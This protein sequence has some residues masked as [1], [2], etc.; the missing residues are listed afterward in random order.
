MRDNTDA[1]LA[2]VARG[3]QVFPLHSPQGDACDCNKRDCASPAKHPRTMHGLLDATDNA[4]TISRWWTTWPHANV[5]VAT[6]QAS[7]IVVIDVDPIHGGDEQI[8]ALVAEHGTLPYGPAVKTGSGG[9]HYWFKHPGT[10]V[11]SRN[12]QIAPGVDVKGD[13]GYVVAPPSVHATGVSYEWYADLEDA[14]LPA[15]PDWLYER[16]IARQE[17]GETGAA[18]LP[19]NIAEG[20]RNSTLTSWAGV[21]RARGASQGEMFAFLLELNAQRCNPPLDRSEVAQIAASIARKEPTQAIPMLTQSAPAKT[22]RSSCAVPRTLTLREIQSKVYDP[23]KWA[24]PGLMPVGLTLLAGRSKMGKSWMMM[25]IA[26]AIAEGGLAF[27]STPVED[28]DV[29]YLAYEDYEARWQGRGK[30]LL[31]EVQLWPDRLH[32]A[33]T[34]CWPQRDDGGLEAIDA[35]LGQHPRARLVVMDTL[36]RFRGADATEGDKNA[37]AADYK[38]SGDLQELALKHEVAFAAVHHFR[39]SLSEVDWVDQ[40]SGTN[41]IGAA[42]DVIWGFVRERGD[43]KA[44]ILKTTGRDVMEEELAL[45]WDTTKYGWYVSGTAEELRGTQE[46]QEFSEAVWELG[47]GEPVHY[48][49]IAEVIG[50]KQNT[51]YQMGR[52]LT[53]RGDVIAVGGGFYKVVSTPVNAVKMAEN[54]Y[55][56]PLTGGVST[57][58]NEDGGADTVLTGVDMPLTGGVSKASAPKTLDFDSVDSKPSFRVVGGTKAPDEP[59]PTCGEV[60]WVPRA[61]GGWVCGTCKPWQTEVSR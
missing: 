56:N 43:N 35:W 29:L 34:G 27:G 9:Q 23:P 57:P 28:G 18:H 51:V 47:H 55:E 58:V 54:R 44:A 25:G 30:T 45:S 14:E 42:A 36:Q 22:G 52:R 15:M 41:G 33:P 17:Q 38:V 53:Q 1:A 4:D 32:V 5:G 12:G 50:K 2:L 11:P 49:R 39:K 8:M 20:Q 3:L 48:K 10:P 60:A 19:E 61:A 46:A 37:Y 16:A 59:C 6:G 7:G 24:V 40:I 26:I 13:G 21:L 31:G